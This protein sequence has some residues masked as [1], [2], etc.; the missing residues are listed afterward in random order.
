MT[1]PPFPQPQLEPIGIN[2]DQYCEYTPEKLELSN[3]MYGYG[4]QELTGFYL[5]VLAN[6]GIRAAVQNVPLSLWLEAIQEL[7]TNNP[8]LSLKNPESEAMLNQFNRAI[9]DLKAVAHYLD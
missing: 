4:G 5:A 6:M 1:N 8:K 2:I 7:A 9:A 3:G